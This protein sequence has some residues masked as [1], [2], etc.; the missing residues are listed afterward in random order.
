MAAAGGGKIR[1]RRYHI[2][3]KPYAKGKQQ[4]GIISRVTDTVKSIVPGWLQKYFKNGE[5]TDTETE[6]VR[7]GADEQ[8]THRSSRDP[9]DEE[10][11]VHLPDRTSTQEPTTSNAEP[12]TSR[13]ALNFQDVLARPPLNRSHLNL[14]TL[15]SP[16]LHSQPSTSTA[17]PINS[18]GFSLVK[19]IKDSTSQHEDDNIS[20]TS[21]F[22]SRASDKDVT[23]SKSTCLPPLWSPE[24]ERFVPHQAGAGLKK[25]AFNLSVFGNSSS[26]LA[27]NS[28][29]NSTQLGDSP[30]YPGKT[31]YGG[32]AAVRTSSRIRGTPYQAPVRRQVKAKPISSS[33][34]GVTSATARRILQSL[35]RMSSP[36]ADAKRIP[37]SLPSPLSTSLD[38]SDLDVTNFQPKRKKVDSAHPPVQKLVTP[39]V[40]SV[41]LNKS[42]SFKPSLTPSGSLS[43]SRKWKENRDRAGRQSNKDAEITVE[44][45][46]STNR[47]SYPLF[48]TPA[49]NGTGSS[50]AGGKM[51]RERA[52][53]NSSKHTRENETI[54]VPDLPNTSLPISTS[55]LP[56]FSFV[57]PPSTAASVPATS[58]VPSA[59]SSPSC[60]A[61]TFSSPIVK[62]TEPNLL[63]P[64]PSAGFTFSAPV[65]KTAPSNSTGKTY[66][67]SVTPVKNSLASSSTSGSAQNNEVFEGPFKPAKTLKEGSVLDILKGSGFS[68]PLTSRNTPIPV[69][70]FQTNTS[71]NS[72]A[73]GIA[74]GDKF[75]PA[76]GSWQCNTCLLQNG[77]SDGKCVACLS[78]KPGTDS[79]KQGPGLGSGSKPSITEP[80]PSFVDKFRPAAGS[81]ECDTCLVQNKSDVIKC[82][83]CETPKPGTG[84]KPALTMPAVSE[85][86]S[87]AT[88]SGSSTSST[89]A[90]GTAVST[91]SSGV[92]FG[93]LFKKKE[94]AWQCEV[95]LVENK[96]EDSKCVACQ[97]TKAGAAPAD[98]T[99]GP[100]PLGGS[101]Q[102]FGDKFKKP[103]G[104][105]DCDVCCVQNKAEATQCVACQSARPGA[106]VEPKGFTSLSSNTAASPFT[107][108]IQSSS[109]T[110]SPA[111]TNTGGFT[112]GD[113]GGIKFGSTTTDSSASS[114][115]VSS[116]AFGVSFKFG[117][118]SSASTETDDSKKGDAQAF[119]SGF[120]FGIT[121]GITFGT[122]NSA[123]NHTENKSESTSK[124]SLEGFSFGLSTPAKAEEKPTEGGLTFAASKEKSEQAGSVPPAAAVFSFGKTE[125]KK[126]VVEQTPALSFNFG[127]PVEKELVVPVSSTPAP[128]PAPAAPVFAF[129]KLEEKQDTG[130]SSSGFLFNS[131]KEA[132]KS[133]PQLGFSFGK[134]APPKEETKSAFS[135]AKPAENQDAAEPPKPAFAFGAAAAEQGAPKPAFSFLAG[136]SSSTAPVAPTTAASLF[137]NASSSATS[138]PAPAFVF[139]QGSSSEGTPAKTFMFG[140]QETKPPAAP[141]A[142]TTVQPFMF[143]SSNATPPFN[144]VATAPSTA[145][146]TGS[147]APPFVFGS[148]SSSSSTSA[149][150]FGVNQAPAFGQGS[151]QPSAPAFG[152][153][154]ASLFSAGSQPASFG[155]P[156]NSQA[157]VFGQQNNQQPAFGSTAAPANPG[158]GFQFGATSAFGAPT[159]GGVFTF[160]GPGASSGP[161]TAPAVP[162]QPSAPTAGF[163]FS[164]PPAFNIGSAKS[165]FNTPT[166]GQHSIAGRKIKT[167]VRRRK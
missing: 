94:G 101:L 3:S 147:S 16:A 41:A 90:G 110:E 71:G 67:S 37:S 31:T 45:P 86:K 146:S 156:A 99:T 153:A 133:A 70:P 38:R 159:S 132:E 143:G 140:S 135:F 69:K 126:A 13:S 91:V 48:S 2:A 59:T 136:G 11:V 160:G 77:P 95:C 68:S 139:G 106:K 28:V 15:D 96:A 30:F 50:R 166:P 154:A 120:K 116:G 142:G 89:V 34:C 93:G 97:S 92:G 56:T 102:G 131:G 112:F 14:S 164:Q 128:A 46:Q 60:A 85:P 61:F 55:A 82:V 33:S 10:D 18:S 76:A 64:S 51:K 98:T 17:F 73:S 125:E 119:G 124:P 100:V 83:A 151:S 155:S 23:T 42:I 122:G 57:C 75:K 81:W 49:A 54:E 27:N 111:T 20:T 117:T 158:G 72:P 35:E 145:S 152:S 26:T 103:E 19:E 21:G 107:F 130:N 109:A 8:E 157:P 134:T 87:T 165:S 36:L 25:P 105:W 162:T 88:S 62:A 39:T 108:G 144:F 9:S 4:Q 84:V 78:A 161:S 148:A 6:E 123:C 141:G 29:L 22:S 79:F 1:T 24:A 32:A 43:S 63:P 149:P 129:G 80:L 114:N 47:F 127:K 104:S 40:A 65:A 66:P 58:K 163:S 5:P 121:S 150:A 7:E 74:L 52:F 113:Q 12:S 53:Q 137:G 44:P 167:A 115:N 138:N 118:S